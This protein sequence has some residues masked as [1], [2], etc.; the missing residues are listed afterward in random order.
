M[1]SLDDMLKRTGSELKK[2]KNYFKSAVP[3][4][5]YFLIDKATQYTEGSQNQINNMLNDGAEA[6]IGLGIVST[7]AAAYIIYR[8]IKNLRESAY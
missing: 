8:Y 2:A 4:A 3:V 6:L 1:K 7:A 5:G